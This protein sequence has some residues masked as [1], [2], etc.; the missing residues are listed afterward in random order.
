M[1]QYSILQ[2]E[3]ELS[4]MVLGTDHSNECFLNFE[5]I[6]SDQYHNLNPQRPWSERPSKGTDLRP[7]KDRLV[8]P[9]IKRPTSNTETLVLSEF[10]TSLMVKFFR[11]SVENFL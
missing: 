8:S 7:A 3:L 10:N 9:W 2:Y 11:W 6:N 4:R 5:P 1:N